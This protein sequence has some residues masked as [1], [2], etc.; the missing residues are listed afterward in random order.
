MEYK[1]GISYALT[2]NGREREAK[3]ILKDYI[4]MLSGYKI[5]AIRDKEN[6]V[7]GLNVTNGRIK[8]VIFKKT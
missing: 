8:N 1:E 2:K 4:R 6:K 7:V 3:I 5:Y